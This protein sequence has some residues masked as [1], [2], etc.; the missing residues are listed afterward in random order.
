MLQYADHKNPAKK[1]KTNDGSCSSI[2]IGLDEED[3]PS[4]AGSGRK[5]MMGR[6]WEKDRVARDGAATKMSTTWKD[7]F[8]KKDESMQKLEKEREDRK[9]ERYDAFL[10]LQREIIEFDRLRL[11]ERMDIERARLELVKEEAWMK[12]RLEKKKMQD[13][14]A[15]EQEK[16]LLARIT[17]EQRIMFQDASLLDE[18]SAKWV[19]MMKKRNSDR[20]LDLDGFGGTAP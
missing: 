6:R 16:V 20:D 11:K 7:I 3:G 14:L 12:V 2:P 10:A 1:W 19:L 13:A 8:S 18:P 17:K 4:E 15:M 9:A 5:R